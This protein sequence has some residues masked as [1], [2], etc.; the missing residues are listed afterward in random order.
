M[1]HR[2]SAFL[3]VEYL[4]KGVTLDGYQLGD[5]ISL[6][7]RTVLLGQPTA[8]QSAPDI[9]INDSEKHISGSHAEIRYDPEEYNY[10]ICDFSRNGTSVGPRRLTKN[11]EQLLEPGDPICLAIIAGE[12]R[13]EFSFN[14]SRTAGPMHLTI[15][16]RE[17]YVDNEPLEVSDIEY[18]VLKALYISY[19]TPKFCHKDDLI[20]A[21]W[22]KKGWEAAETTKE[23]DDY[24]DR[25]AHAISRLRK[26]FMRANPNSPIRIESSGRQG[27]YRLKLPEKE[28]NK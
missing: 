21:V 16:G 22:G 25:L 7:A 1:G 26:K 11:I 18:K 15:K 9:K 12:P 6:G 13:V 24:R 14:T 27:L 28:R 17:V 4:A 8:G 19:P 20:V 3:R 23:K 2:E 10:K 5:E